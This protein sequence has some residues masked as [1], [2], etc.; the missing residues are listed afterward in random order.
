MKM[1]TP[2]S[3]MRGCSASKRFTAGDIAVRIPFSKV[4]GIERKNLTGD[5]DNVF[6]VLEFCFTS[7]G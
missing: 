6:N 1:T 3:T 5:L 2:C 7:K 4:S